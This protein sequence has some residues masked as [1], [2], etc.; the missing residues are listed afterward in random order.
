MTH[1]NPPTPL[2]LTPTRERVRRKAASFKRRAES[3]APGSTRTA[4]ILI[5]AAHPIQLSNVSGLV[6]SESDNHPESRGG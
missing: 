4:R 3:D 6:S 2:L 5:Y 1:H